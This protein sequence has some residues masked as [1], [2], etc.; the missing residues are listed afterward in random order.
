M[1][2]FFL[3]CR[4]VGNFLAYSPEFCFVAEDS[5]SI[6]GYILASVNAKELAS[7]SNNLWV[8]AMKEKYPRPEREDFSPSDVS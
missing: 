4:L 5:E 6:C 3:S 2:L 1:E 7:K 8:P